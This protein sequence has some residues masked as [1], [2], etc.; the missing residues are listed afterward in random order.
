MKAVPQF[1]TSAGQLLFYYTDGRTVWNKFHQPMSN[2]NYALS[3][4]YDGLHGDPSST[5]SGLIL[6]HPTESHLYYVFT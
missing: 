2:A 1:S 5:S 6:P 3:T 4:N